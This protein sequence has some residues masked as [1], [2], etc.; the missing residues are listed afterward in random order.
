MKAYLIVT[1]ILWVI[2]FSEA[3]KKSRSANDAFVAITSAA[4]AAWA[5]YLATTL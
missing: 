5:I 4:L 1:A 3:M 2:T